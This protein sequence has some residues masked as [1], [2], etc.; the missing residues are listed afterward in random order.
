M[1]THMRFSPTTCH[2]LLCTNIFFNA[3]YLGSHKLF[4]FLWERSSIML[5]KTSKI[6]VKSQNVILPY[7]PGDNARVIYT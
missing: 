1:K 6:I 2:Y 5:T 7:F 4:S 3:F